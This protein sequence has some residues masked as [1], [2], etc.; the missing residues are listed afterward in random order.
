MSGDDNS[1]QLESLLS[2]LSNISDEQQ[3]DT[4][5]ISVS[6]LYK[7][8]NTK[9]DHAQYDHFESFQMENEKNDNLCYS[10]V[11]DY[12]IYSPIKN[13]KANNENTYHSQ[14][15]YMNLNHK[16]VIS[17]PSSAPPQ[18]DCNTKENFKKQRNNK[19]KEYLATTK[20][21]PYK[22][23]LTQDYEHKNA[24]TPSRI[25]QN[26][27]DNDEDD[28]DRVKIL[29]KLFIPQ[30]QLEFMKEFYIQGS[31]CESSDKYLHHMEPYVEWKD[32][33]LGK[34]E[35]Q[36]SQEERKDDS[37]IEEVYTTRRVDPNQQCWDNNDKYYSSYDCSVRRPWETQS[38][39]ELIVPTDVFTKEATKL[40]MCMDNTD[41]SRRKVIS[42]EEKMKFDRK[43]KL[44]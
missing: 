43:R 28:K 41:I 26:N 32:K 24:I 23:L 38:R 3:E 37:S 22:Q 44:H 18:N 35:L 13:I 21:F 36:S 7:E 33:W 12:A 8:D 19:R 20:S 1:L 34:Q 10:P 16:P 9:D 15:E 5:T 25:W 6:A 39:V 2:P 30:W 11:N 29:E 4:R 31:S 27:E 14:Q 40:M 42:Y 17:W